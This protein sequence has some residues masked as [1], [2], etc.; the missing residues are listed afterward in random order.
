MKRAHSTPV[1]QRALH[2]TTGDLAFV[3]MPCTFRLVFFLLFGSGCVVSLIYSSVSI[4]MRHVTWNSFETYS[5]NE[6]LFAIHSRSAMTIQ[7]AV[8]M[9]IHAHTH[10]VG[11]ESETTRDCTANRRKNPTF[12]YSMLWAAFLRALKSTYVTADF[13]SSDYNVCATYSSL[14]RLLA[15]SRTLSRIKH[16][17]TLLD[18]VSKSLLY[19][20]LR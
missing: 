17:W 15:R 3:L 1:C 20:S 7:M 16:S 4:W 10:I 12:I 2:I 14:V 19:Y 9:I 13:V 18:A 5:I 8:N 6:N 11:F